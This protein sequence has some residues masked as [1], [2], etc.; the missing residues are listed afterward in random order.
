MPPPPLPPRDRGKATAAGRL[1]A[2]QRVHP[3]VMPAND[4]TASTHSLHYQNPPTDALLHQ[5][6]HQVSA[7]STRPALPPPRIP[8]KSEDIEMTF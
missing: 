1:P 7:T 2:R 3:L 8:L 6:P 5:D 4:Q